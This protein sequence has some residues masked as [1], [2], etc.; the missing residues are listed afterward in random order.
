[1]RIILPVLTAICLAVSAAEAQRICVEE[2][3]GTCLK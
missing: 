3:A 2:L 1:M